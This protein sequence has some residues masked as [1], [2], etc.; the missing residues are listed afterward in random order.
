MVFAFRCQTR[1]WHG[2]YCT[3]RWLP[4]VF[5]EAVFSVASMAAEKTF[6]RI[7]AGKACL[8]SAASTRSAQ[9]PPRQRR[10][11]PLCRILSPVGPQSCGTRNL[12]LRLWPAWTRAPSLQGCIYG[13]SQNKVS[14][15]AAD[16]TQSDTWTRLPSLQGCIYGGSQNKASCTAADVTQPD[17]RTR[18]QAYIDVFTAYLRTG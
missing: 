2:G 15:T 4:A 18:P 13:G 12:V 17:A 6:S 16:E 11:N 10:Y 1:L 5:N 3:P 7:N 8:F 14:C 9:H